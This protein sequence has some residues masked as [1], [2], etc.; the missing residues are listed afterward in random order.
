MD[1][2][3]KHNPDLAD[4]LPRNYGAVGDDILRELIK[5]LAPV[6]IDGD[7]FG[8][9]YEYFMGNF[10]MQEMLKGGE[11]YTPSSIVR[12]IVEIIEPYHR[13]QGFSSERRKPRR[14]R[15]SDR[16]ARCGP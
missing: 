6:R 12:L 1:D 8:R 9:V 15:R 4:A 13:L 14:C 7:A 11:F 16:R 3:E 10:A 2:I 5:E